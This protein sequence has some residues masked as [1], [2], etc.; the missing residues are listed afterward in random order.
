[1]P[2]QFQ[3]TDT[4]N[5][6]KLQNKWTGAE[7]D[8]QY[9]GYSECGG[10]IQ[11]SS[12][13][14]DAATFELVASCNE[15]MSGPNHRDYRGC[16]S[17]TRIGRTCQAW[18]AQ[19]PH[20]H[21]YTPEQRPD[22]GLGDHNQ[23]RNPGGALTIWCYTTDSDPKWRWEYCDPEPQSEFKMKLVSD[24][25]G[26]YG[27]LSYADKDHTE[28]PKGSIQADYTA[29]SAM[30]FNLHRDCPAEPPAAEVP[31]EEVANL[32]ESSPMQITDASANLAAKSHA[33]QILQE[34]PLTIGLAAGALALVAV[35]GV[36]RSRRKTGDLYVALTEQET[37]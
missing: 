26:K 36:R 19:T 11:A 9:L 16:Q 4:C 32:A 8:D 14:D 23:C 7:A 6:Y 30:T 27:Y 12:S 22:R 13:E 25:V 20:S 28:H 3:A 35:S 2:L 33:M 34:N 15:T 18:T 10:W 17:K 31:A 21:D 5:Q 29:A 1:M 37:A 24:P